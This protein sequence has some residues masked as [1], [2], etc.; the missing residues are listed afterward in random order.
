MEER[1][2]SAELDRAA[3]GAIAD[4]PAPSGET[5]AGKSESGRQLLKS[6]VDLSIAPPGKKGVK[7]AAQLPAATFVL[8]A[9]G[10]AV[11]LANNNASRFGRYTELQFSDAGRL[12]GVKGLEYYLEKSRVTGASAGERASR[13]QS[14]AL[15]PATR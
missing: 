2:R 10:S 13:S 12:V 7:L 15:L 14:C 1:G 3:R 5:G 8:D 9:F 11:T 4:L 6:L